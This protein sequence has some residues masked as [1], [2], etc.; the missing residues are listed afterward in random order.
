MK[1]TLKT[2]KGFTLVEIVAVVAI[3]VIL[4]GALF[5]SVSE[6]LNSTQR[7]KADREQEFADYK[8]SASANEVRLAGYNF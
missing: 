1:R 4:A 7:S 6:I 3:I 2:K 8:A 5:I